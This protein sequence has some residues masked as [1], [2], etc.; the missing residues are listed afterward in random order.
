MLKTESNFIIFIIICDRSGVL[1]RICARK[2]GIKENFVIK[3]EV[4]SEKC[5]STFFYIQYCIF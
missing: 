2:S 5:M 1:R 3:D 4:V